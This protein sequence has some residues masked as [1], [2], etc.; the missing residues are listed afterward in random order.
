MEEPL[1]HAA[2]RLTGQRRTRKENH[3]GKILHSQ[4]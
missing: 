2:A 4:R 3:S 1:V